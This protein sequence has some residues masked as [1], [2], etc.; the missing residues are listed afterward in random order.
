MDSYEEAVR[1]HQMQYKKNPISVIC[2]HTLT[3]VVC[4]LSVRVYA[5]VSTGSFFPCNQMYT[6][7]PPWCSITNKRFALCGSNT[8][9]FLEA[10]VIYGDKTHVK[11]IQELK[12]LKTQV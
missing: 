12:P 9:C 1:L 6:E 2:I 11:I 7:T 10:A 3:A 4:S 5:G 8:A